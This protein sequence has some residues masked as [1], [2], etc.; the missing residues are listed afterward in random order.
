LERA[1]LTSG[2]AGEAMASG[3]P[4]TSETTRHVFSN[5]AEKMDPALQVHDPKA[6]YSEVPAK[7]RARLNSDKDHDVLIRMEV[8][9]R[10]TRMLLPDITGQELADY[11]ALAENCD[12]FDR[13]LRFRRDAPVSGRS[14]TAIAWIIGTFAIIALLAT[15]LIAAIAVSV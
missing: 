5:F 7:I 8:L 15:G 11:L 6:S 2:T 13:W 4:Q 12:D 10:K 1:L 3:L 9:A 14:Y